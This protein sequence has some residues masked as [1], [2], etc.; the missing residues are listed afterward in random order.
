MYDVDSICVFFAP[1]AFCNLSAPLGLLISGY[2]AMKGLGF[3]N[4][5]AAAT[6]RSNERGE[7][8]HQLSSWSPYSIQKHISEQSNGANNQDLTNCIF[9]NI[10]ILLFSPY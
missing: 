2:Y 5:T 4:V 3:Y 6:A 1:G 8:H 10:L 9:V 7:G